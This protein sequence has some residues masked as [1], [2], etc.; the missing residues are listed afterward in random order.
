MGI[1]KPKKLRLKEFGYQL[2][3]REGKFYQGQGNACPVENGPAA[4]K[5]SDE[6]SGNSATDLR[7][8]GV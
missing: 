7:F 5:P 8:T 2:S 4:T 3:M 1:P 6:F